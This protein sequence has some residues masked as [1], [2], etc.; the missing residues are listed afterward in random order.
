M[1]HVTNILLKHETVASGWQSDNLV[2]L[3][4]DEIHICLNN[5]GESAPYQIQKAARK[6]ENLGVKHAKL[7]GDIWDEHT[8]WA[9]ALGFTCVGKLTNVEF[10]GDSELLNTLNNKLAVFAWSRDLTMTLASPI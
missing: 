10:T 4:D 8:Q 9:F 6:I 7:C 1:T 3:I 2:Q 5:T